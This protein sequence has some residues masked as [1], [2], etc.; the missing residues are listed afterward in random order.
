MPEGQWQIAPGRAGRE[1]L[2]LL[3]TVGPRAIKN[4]IEVGRAEASPGQDQPVSACGLRAAF[5]RVLL[6]KERERDKKER[7]KIWTEGRKLK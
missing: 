1:K 3:A 5:G 7:E 4:E 2:Q 6:Y